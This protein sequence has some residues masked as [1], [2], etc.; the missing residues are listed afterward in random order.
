VAWL[1]EQWRDPARRALWIEAG[2]SC[3]IVFGSALLAYLRK[4]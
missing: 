3:L 2:V 1:G 4:L